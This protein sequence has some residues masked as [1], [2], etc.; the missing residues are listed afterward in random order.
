M[1]N[2]KRYDTILK[3]FDQITRQMADPEVIRN[4]SVYRDLAVERSALEEAVAEIKN[5]FE[6]EKRMEE[7]KEVVEN[8]DDAELVEFA[9]ME[10]VEIKED[11]NKIEKEINLLLIPKDPDDSRNTIFEIRA[12]TGGN[13]AAIFA[14]DLARMYR[15]YAEKHKWKLDLLGSHPSEAGGFKEMIFMLSGRQAFGKLKFESGVHRVQRVPE[16]ESGGRIH[17]SAVTV[18]V[19]PEAKEIDIKIDQKDLKIDVFRASGPGGQSVNMTDSAVR[20]THIP[21]GLV[22]SCQDEKSQH[23]NRD[24]ALK[25]LRARLFEA[26]K[27]ERDRKR[28]QKR[29][30]MV[31]SGDRSA[32]IRT[33]NYPQGRVS[34]HRINFTT[35]NL[36]GVMDGDLDEII[37]ALLLAEREKKLSE[38][39]E[40]ARGKSSK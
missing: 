32:K 2:K 15:L 14:G 21:S 26:A 6:L 1:N 29:K 34:D 13:E 5:Y 12:G 23:K 17:T 38:E 33:Y 16:T 35:H 11:L 31:G 9:K 22:V 37:E 36:K 24:K 19:L 28:A 25:V 7:D 30:S 18:A 10:I 3:R 20:I 27:K 40:K 39:I 4:Q 8:S